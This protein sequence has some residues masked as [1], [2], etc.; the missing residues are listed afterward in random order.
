M[1]LWDCGGMGDTRCMT[2]NENTW[3]RTS[4]PRAADTIYTSTTGY[5]VRGTGSTSRR[6]VTYA[7]TGDQLPTGS[8]GTLRQAKAYADNHATGTAATKGPA[9]P[10]LTVVTHADGTVSTRKSQTRAY[11]HAVEVS[12]APA[13]AYAAHLIRQAEEKETKATNLLTAAAL[14][15]GSIQSRGFGGESSHHSHRA[16]L[17]NTTVYTWCGPDHLTADHSNRGTDGEPAL[18]PV[19]PYLIRIARE[20]AADATTEAARLRA[21]AAA[22]LAAGVPVGEYMVSRWS[23]RADL[24]QAGLREAAW[25]V[26]QGRT[27]RVVPVD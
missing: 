22:V 27:V 4:A 16:S 2:T 8:F 14:G 12:P 9:K 17:D 13:A 24:A 6:F 23:T 7:P 5:K 15:K 26:A 10:G 21:E 18:V 11:T 20:S 25:Y 3:K 19:L 1:G